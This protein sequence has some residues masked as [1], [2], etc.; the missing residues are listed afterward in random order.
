MRKKLL[1]YAMITVVCL[2]TIGWVGGC[3]PVGL[4]QRNCV[5][6]IGDSI[7]ALTGQITRHLQDIS[8]QRYRTYY[9]S[10]AQMNGGMVM[11]IEAQYDMAQRQGNIR[12][13]IMDG[14]GND[15]FFGNQLN[16]ESIAREITAAWTRILDKAQQDNVENIVVLG[17]YVTATTPD[18]TDLDPSGM[19]PTLIEGAARR[20]INLVYVDPMTD[21]FFTSRRPAQYTIDSIHPTT[22]AA[23]KLADMIWAAMQ[24]ND[25][26]QGPGCAGWSPN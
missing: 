18:N 17:Y 10:G 25:I 24:A 1:T 22:A 8:H 9:I 16:P 21:S 11:D 15:F 19:G 20:G 3:T 13:L 14:G 2:V 7:F 6:M 4:E 5:A 26:E 23:N 12:T